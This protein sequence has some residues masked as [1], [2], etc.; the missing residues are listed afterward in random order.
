MTV[1]L[2]SLYYIIVKYFNENEDL[3]TLSE[4]GLEQKEALIYLAALETGGGTITELASHCHIERTG[5]YYH[6][7]KLLAQKLIKTVE[8][9]KRTFYLPSDPNR[10]K[11]I[12][13]KRQARFEQIFPKME[14]R[15]SKKASKS[16]IKYY[17]GQD[18]VD[19]FYD[20]V[21]S[22]LKSLPSDQNMIYIFGTSYKTVL[23]NNQ[24]FLNFTKPLE[25]INIRSKAILPQLQKAKNASELERNPYIISRYNLPLSEI[26]YISDRYSYPG[27]TVITQN[28]IILYDWRNYMFSITENRN[29]AATWRSFFELI[30]DL[31]K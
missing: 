10:L 2:C 8:R 3:K 28:H 30:W 17:E 23:E 26:K 4:L 14:E 9:G 19:N 12:F 6:L 18:E 27:S 5:I 22:L 31:L 7:E 24:H 15:F 11:H 25:Q 29:N 20:H 13:Q 1:G 16:I 21:Y